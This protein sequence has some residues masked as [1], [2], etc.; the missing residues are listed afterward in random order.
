M[1]KQFIINELFKSFTRGK[2]IILFGASRR[3]KIVADIIEKYRLGKVEFF[4]DD[5]KYNDT[6]TYKSEKLKYID[7]EK[8]IIIICTDMEGAYKKI[9]NQLINLNYEEN[10]H[11]FS[12][13]VLK[14]Q[15]ISDSN[16][17]YE[18]YD[19]ISTYAPWLADFEFMKY[20]SMIKENT[21]VD[22]Y[23]CYELWRLVEE[24][25]KLEKGI[26]L[27]VGVWRGGTG[28]LIAKKSQLLGIDEKVYLCDTFT[29]VVK[30]SSKDNFYIGGE[31]ADTSLNC[32]YELME[33]L[34]LNNI[35]FLKGIFPDET[36][37]NIDDQ[38]RFCHI[39]VDVFKSGKEIIDFVWP[40]LV[41]GGIVVFDDYG[42]DACQGITVLVNSLKSDKDKIIIENLN[43]HAI[44]VKIS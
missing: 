23:R 41:K 42:F 35:E 5:F 15:L 8:Y 7:K 25:N 34:E 31:H 16:N 39:D 37:F 2:N 32:A 43:G 1:D 14:S 10:R 40:K 29:G 6:N 13:R 27:E 19:I 3:G 4:I 26:L 38:I 28:A 24:S 18:D 36:G 17:P 11:F 30:A 44:L 9:K 33:R 12:S 22:I 21:L 20:F